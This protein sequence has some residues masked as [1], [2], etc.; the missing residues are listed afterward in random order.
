MNIEVLDILKVTLNFTYVSNIPRDGSYGVLNNGSW[1]GVMG[2]L[3]N[4]KADFSICDLSVTKLRSQS[5]EFTVG[6][7][8]SSCRLYMQK[9]GRSVSY[10]TFTDV[11]DPTF[12]GIFAATILG[13]CMI[14][15]FIMYFVKG[16]WLISSV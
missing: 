5:V 1:S 2:E 14:F 16:T 10:T 4:R 15:Y 6:L 13:L 7:I 12:W 3:A 11:F 8:F 9:P